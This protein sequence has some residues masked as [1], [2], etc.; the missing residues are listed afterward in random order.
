MTKNNNQSQ[1]S[2]IEI[3]LVPDIKKELLIAQR[4]RNQVSVL[5][6]IIT[7]VILSLVIMLAMFIFIYQSQKINSLRVESDR[8]SNQID[9]IEGVDRILTIQN[10]LSKINQIH[11]NKPITSRIFYLMLGIVRDNNLPIKISSLEYDPHY[12]DGPY[13]IISGKTDKGY[14]ALEQLKKTI[15]DSK[16]KYFNIGQEQNINSSDDAEQDQDSEEVPLTEEVYYLSTPTLLEEGDEKVLRFK[17][18][19]LIEERFFTNL[20]QGSVSFSRIGKKDVTDSSLA[21]PDDIFDDSPIKDQE[22]K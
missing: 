3:S 10:Q 13:V 14:V 1:F 7:S 12:S 20:K 19:F 6:I 2:M 11:D 22:N 21:I 4:V 17:I 5:A 15:L 16:I 9:N 18:G 8:L